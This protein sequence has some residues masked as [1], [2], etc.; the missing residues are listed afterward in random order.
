VRLHAA[1]ALGRIGEQQAVPALLDQARGDRFEAARSAAQALAVC[2]PAALLR[3]AA[4]PGAGPHLHE[5]A[6]LLGV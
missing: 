6:D 4:A 3:A 5:A 1:R 2:D